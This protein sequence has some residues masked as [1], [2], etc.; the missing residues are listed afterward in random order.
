MLWVGRLDEQKGFPVAVR[1]FASLAA[2]FPDLS[3][4]VVG[5]GRDRTAVSTL[6]GEAR[7]RV[8]LAG[9]V[10]HRDLPGYVAAADVFVAPALGQESFGIVLVEAMAAGVPVVASDIFGY[11]EVVRPDEDGILVPPD[12]PGALAGAVRRVLSDEALAARLAQAGRARAERF[13]WEVVIDEI[14]AVYQEALQ[15]PAVR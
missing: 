14:E 8:V 4:V 1:A 11:R 12:D 6:R 13:R 9:S 10:C 15:N 5:E 2:E 3:F 7:G